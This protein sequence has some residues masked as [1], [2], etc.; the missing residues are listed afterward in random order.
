[1]GTESPIEERMAA[2]LKELGIPY[3]TQ[4]E[5]GQQTFPGY[6]RSQYADDCNYFWDEGCHYEAEC[7][8]W[9]GAK[10]YPLY[11]LDF[12]VCIGRHKIA[13]ECDGFHFHRS[14][15]DQL[16]KDAER[17]IWLR[18]NGWTVKRWFGTTI[19]SRPSVVKR[20][21]KQLWATIQEE[22]KP[23]TLS[24]FDV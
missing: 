20:D 6:C 19:T 1:M 23:K 13:I 21:L 24:L 4:V 8:W 10:S 5:V 16:S 3:E 15:G 18:Q 22:M 9:M 7:E 11:R 2:I 12:A 14:T 17:D